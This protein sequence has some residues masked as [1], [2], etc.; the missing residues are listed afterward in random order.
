MLDLLESYRLNVTV[1]QLA[2]V[3]DASAL[4]SGQRSNRSK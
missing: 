4:R 2:S 1:G 3:Q